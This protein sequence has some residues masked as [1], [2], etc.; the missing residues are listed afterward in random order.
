MPLPT[1]YNSPSPDSIAYGV[2]P[3]LV[4]APVGT[5]KLGM[6]TEPA[7]FG[8][9]LLVHVLAVHEQASDALIGCASSEVS[10]SFPDKSVPIPH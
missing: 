3:P 6:I 5:L 9:A 8:L 7:V 4:N 1:L 2:L 10:S